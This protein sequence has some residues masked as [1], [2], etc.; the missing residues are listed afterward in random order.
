MQLIS[1]W[2]DNS[3]LSRVEKVIYEPWNLKKKNIK[4]DVKANA[5][6]RNS[7]YNINDCSRIMS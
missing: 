5:G 6:M 1:I 3:L 4:M 2:A 7:Q